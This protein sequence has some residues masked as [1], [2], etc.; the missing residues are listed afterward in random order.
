MTDAMGRRDK[1]FLGLAGLFVSSLVIANIITFKLFSAPLPGGLELFGQDAVVL[2]AGVLPYPLT[3]LVTDLLSEL[4]GKERASAVVWTGFWASLWVLV[5]IRV[6]SWVPPV[7]TEAHTPEEVQALYTGVFGQSSRAIIASMTAYLVA[8]LF[9]VRIFHFWK[10]VTGGRH[11]WLRNNGSTIFS[12]M[13]DTVLVVSILFWN[14]LPPA[15][16]VQVIAASYVFKLLAALVDT[17]LFYLG[18]YWLRR[19]MGEPEEAEEE[20]V[21]AVAG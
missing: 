17:P 10:R 18:A 7:G 9:D 14:V 8:Q 3:F 4:Y 15:T 5:V 12:Q 6:G 1:V 19:W 16:I 2:A 13:L 21:A 20:V 11:M